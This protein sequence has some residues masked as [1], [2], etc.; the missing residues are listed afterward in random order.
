M[1][2]NFLKVKDS[3][4]SYPTA[5]NSVETLLIH[6]DLISTNEFTAIIDLLEKENVKIHSGPNLS[7]LIKFAPSIVDTFRKEYS[8]LEIT[9]E[10]VDSV[11]AAVSH[12]NSYGSH[13]TDSIITKNSLIAEY[14]LKNIDSACVFH[15]AST[16]FSDGY[17]FGL[18][19]E[20]GISTGRLHARGPVGV[21]GLL[22]TKW[23]L[24]SVHG[25]TA[26][27]FTNG[28]K[29]FT[30]ETIDPLI[31]NKSIDEDYYSN[32][33]FSRKL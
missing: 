19:A 16:R 24:Q 29:T 5:C 9:I 3:K 27:E 4:C 33:K 30:H 31:F 21:E 28:T 14:F 25:D 8:D 2:F 15:N 7:K 11:Q 23:I 10:A 12:I 20:V 32:E 1:Y 26:D 18:G 13:H 17:R 6:T 22:T